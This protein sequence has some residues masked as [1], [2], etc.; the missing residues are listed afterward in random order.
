[1]LRDGAQGN[2]RNFNA[3]AAIFVMKARFG[4]H[5][6]GPKDEPQEPTTLAFTD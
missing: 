3:A 6:D 5:E 4:W 1:V 2:I